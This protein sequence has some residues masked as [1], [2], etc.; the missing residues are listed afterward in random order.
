ML[1]AVVTSVS[2]VAPA[3]LERYQRYL[4]TA[5]RGAQYRLAHRGTVRFF[6]RY[7]QFLGSAALR[8]DPRTID[9]WNEKRRRAA[10][11]AT[12]RIPGQVHSRLLVWAL[13]FV[14]EFSGDILTAIQH[15]QQLRGPRDP[16]SSIGRGRTGLAVDVRAY[17]EAAIRDKRPLPGYNGNP[18]RIAIARGIGC[19]PRSLL[20][21]QAAIAAAAALVGVSD[22]SQ[23]NA[24][25]TGRLD[26]HPWIDGICVETRRDDSLTVLTQV[27]QAACYIVIAFLSGM[28]DCEVKHLRKGCVSVLR[29]GNGAPTGGEPQTWRSKANTTPPGSPRPG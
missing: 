27:L 10:D 21:H 2:Q 3:D 28:R 11:S 13:R 19:T 15:W 4:L 9:G 1:V 29:D 23:L 8:F 5:F 20:R 22:Y 16:A 24:K 17:L 6:W 12:D 14:D 18:N 7:R 25:I 26:G